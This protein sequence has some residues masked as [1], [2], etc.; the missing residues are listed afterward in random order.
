MHEIYQDPGK[1]PDCSSWK[2]A[3]KQ[4]LVMR[5]FTSQTPCGETP[6]GFTI[7]CAVFPSFIL[8]P[9]QTQNRF[10]VCFTSS[11][12]MLLSF[13]ASAGDGVCVS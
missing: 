11:P 4:L 8:F 12:G 9:F 7:H 6:A 1:P 10:S 5:P 3:G 13:L 2:G